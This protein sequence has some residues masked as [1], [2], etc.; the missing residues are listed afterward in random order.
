MCVCLCVCTCQIMSKT[1]LVTLFP[2]F[3]DI[4]DCS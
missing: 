3:Y 4:N 2:A 1:S